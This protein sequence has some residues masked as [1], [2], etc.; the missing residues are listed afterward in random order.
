M[1][2]T[3]AGMVFRSSDPVAVTSGHLIQRARVVITNAADGPMAV[4]RSRPT[5]I[6]KAD[7]LRVTSG[8]ELTV[9]GL[10]QQAA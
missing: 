10:L 9:S 4:E 6:P 5:V 7:W 2:L 1:L 3:S 8:S